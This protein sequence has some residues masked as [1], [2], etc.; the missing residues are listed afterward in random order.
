MFRL[1]LLV[2]R[3]V[4]RT[5]DWNL[6]LSLFRLLDRAARRLAAEVRSLRRVRCA[7]RFKAGVL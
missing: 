7:T 3:E 1:I 5:G 2:T 6:P 4:E